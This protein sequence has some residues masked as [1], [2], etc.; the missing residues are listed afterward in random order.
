[1]KSAIFIASVL[2][3]F[4]CESENNLAPKDIPLSSSYEWILSSISPANPINFYMYDQ[5]GN[6]LYAYGLENG[7]YGFYKLEGNSWSLI[8]KVIQRGIDSNVESF[9]IYNNEIYYSSWNSL[10]RLEDGV[11]KEIFTSP[12]GIIIE[13]IFIDD[14]ILISGQ[15]LQLNGKSYTMLS[16][17][18]IQFEPVS[19]HIIYQAKSIRLKDKILFAGKPGATY[20]GTKVTP[21]NFYGLFFGA[22]DEGNIYGF[23]DTPDF[24]KIYKSKGNQ[25]TLIGEPTYISVF[26]YNL[27]SLDLIDETKVIFGTDGQSNAFTL[28]LNKNIWEEVKLPQPKFFHSVV[29]YNGRILASTEDGNL[30]ELV[31]K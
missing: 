19:N 21:N 4:S 6:D 2:L 7:S 16:F 14:K 12:V 10:Y 3:I 29:N 23:K 8:E 5:R 28:V 17:N 20:D 18:G 13:L 26:N 9:A 31:K 30:L 11:M 22:D 15:E 1:M 27:K 25:M 24:Y